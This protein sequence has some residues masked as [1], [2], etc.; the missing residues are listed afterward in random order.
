L[1][2]YNSVMSMTPTTVLQ[3]VGMGNGEVLTQGAL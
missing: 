2:G 3:T 1:K